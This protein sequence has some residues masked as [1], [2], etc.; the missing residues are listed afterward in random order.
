MSRQILINLISKHRDCWPCLACVS[1][2]YWVYLVR[3]LMASRTLSGSD[4]GAALARSCAAHLHRARR[5]LDCPALAE[6]VVQDVMLRLIAEPPE[7]IAGEPDA[8]VGRMVRNLALDRA[9]R[10]GFERRL[11]C[12]LDLA[13]DTADGSPAPRR[14]RRP[15]GT[16]CAGSRRRWRPCRSRCAPPSACTGSR[17]SRRS[18]SPGAWASHVP[19]CAAS[20]GAGISIASRPSIR[21]APAVRRAPAAHA[22]S[23]TRPSPSARYSAT[24][25]L[26][27]TPS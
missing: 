5:I 6:D 2:L 17:A 9:R 21:A 8:Y 20:C 14:R 18:R 11:F 22:R 13:P 12:P 4:R 26:T 25:R 23:R 7:G 10:R 16:P 1:P 19:W 3:N 15:R 27:S 24:T